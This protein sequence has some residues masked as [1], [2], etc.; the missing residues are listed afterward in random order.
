M[1]LKKRHFSY[2]SNT[3]T[4]I[5]ERDGVMGEKQQRHAAVALCCS[6]VMDDGVIR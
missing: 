1:K 3:H 4:L 6:G 2:L 5:L